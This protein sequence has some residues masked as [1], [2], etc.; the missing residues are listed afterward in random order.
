LPARDL[1]HGEFLDVLRDERLAVLGRQRGEHRAH[2]L[3]RF[4]AL[5]RPVGQRRALDLRQDAIDVRIGFRQQLVD[6]ARAAAALAPAA[7]AQLVARD[8]AD[9]G[10]QAR[11]TFEARQALEREGE[12]VLHDVLGL[13]ALAAEP[14]VHELVERV[15]LA[16]DELAG[17]RA[18]AGE[19]AAAQP[20]LVRAR[21]RGLAIEGSAR[22]ARLA[23]GAF[24]PG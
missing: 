14:P 23:R 16:L 22:E 4:L 3:A 18:L 10:V 19:D 7:L 24:G 15:E 20:Q 21:R 13:V 8:A 17:G 11:A 6:R 5:E 9:P 2:E 12:G 1:G